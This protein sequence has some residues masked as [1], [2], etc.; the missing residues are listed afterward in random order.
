MLSPSGT[1]LVFAGDGP[2]WSTEYLGG[3]QEAEP[4]VA[5][6]ET[7]PD[8]IFRVWVWTGGTPY[9]IPELPP[10][11]PEAMAAYEAYDP[12]RDDPVLECNLPGM[13][14]VTTIAGSRPFEFEQ[15]GEDILM[16][17]Q[18]YNQT[19]VIH[20]G[21]A[22]DPSEVESDAARLFARP[23]GGRDSGCLDEPDQLP[24]LRPTAVVGRTADG[25]DRNPSSGLPSTGTRSRM[26]SGPMTQRRSR[27]RSTGPGFLTWTWQP[28]LEVETDQ[29]RT[30]FRSSLRRF[31]PHLRSG[32]HAA[33]RC[34]RTQGSDP[35]RAD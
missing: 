23:L 7:R 1:E 30:V 5:A 24:V 31:T 18:N 13:P 6:D 20:M 3:G 2:R 32:Q 27:S 12:L 14:R 9:E 29:L 25:S 33:R 16:R 4:E 35:G 15:R 17:S 19:R 8:G 21:E 26:T 34:G 28:G 22:A 11:T 10:L